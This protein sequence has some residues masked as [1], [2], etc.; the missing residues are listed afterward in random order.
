MKLFY[1]FIIVNMVT[2]K[3]I[4]QNYK[5][6]STDKIANDLIKEKILDSNQQYFI[7]DMIVIADYSN[8]LMIKKY[9]FPEACKLLPNV[10]KYFTDKG[11]I[12]R[13]AIVFVTTNNK[14]CKM[15]SLN[16]NSV[17]YIYVASNKGGK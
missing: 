2:Q 9:L 13:Q 16:W 10:E 5:S 8:K 11:L 4:A 7:I 17:V 12:G 1:L 15:Y 3:S 14:I 6:F